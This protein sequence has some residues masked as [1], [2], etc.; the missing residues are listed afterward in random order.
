MVS[1][2]LGKTMNQK[3]SPLEAVQEIIKRFVT[4]LMMGEYAEARDL[5]VEP[6]AWTSSALAQTWTHM[7]GSSTEPVFLAEE[8]ISVDSMDQW[9]ERLEDDLGWGYVPVLNTLVNEAVSAI[10]TQ[11]E[12]GIRLRSVVF[13]RP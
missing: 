4:C 3:E 11:T 10:A 7:M 13:G 5:L 8:A 12:A 6:D 1:L 9:P 2:P